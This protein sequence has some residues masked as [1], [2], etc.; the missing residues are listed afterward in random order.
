VEE[1]EEHFTSLLEQ[2]LEFTGKRKNRVLVLSIPDWGF[3]P[4]AAQAYPLII[5]AEIDRFNEVNRRVTMAM[6]IHYIYI[7]DWTR[8]A[9]TDPG[10]LAADGL[11]PSGKEYRRWARQI[12]DFFKSQID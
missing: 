7:T 11:H 2:A 1:Y 5:T 10:L 12:A 9:K 8:E 6:D 3:T 4:F